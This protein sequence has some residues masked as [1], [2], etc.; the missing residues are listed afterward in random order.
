MS[1]VSTP[2]RSAGIPLSTVLPGMAVAILSMWATHCAP[3]ASS[4]HE[5]APEASTV[6]EFAPISPE[7]SAYAVEPPK[8][9]AS[10]HELT[11][12]SAHESTPE[13]SFDHESAPVP[14]EVA[15]PAAEPPKG[16]A[17]SYELSAH[18][19]TA[20]E[21]YHKLSACPVTAMEATYEFSAHHVKAKEVNH[22]LSAL[23]WMS[24]APLWVSLL[25]SA[26][27]APPW[28][29]ALPAL[30]ALPWLPALS[31]PPWLPALPA[32]PWLP[33]L[34]APPWLQA[35]QNLPWWTSAPVL[36]C[37]RPRSS[38]ASLSVTAPRSRPTSSARTWPSVPPPV[39][40]LSPH[41]PGLF[42]LSAR[43]RS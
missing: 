38:S 19:V 33:A 22:K 23:L 5:S 2:S 15:A 32:P 16:A 25:L 37:P 27:S 9:V 20:K 8:E 28:L 30:P 39:L 34:P 42:V 24:F 6:H 40:P 7:V 14:P 26:L 18:H 1:T 43:N 17:S 36:H 12:L 10:F 41:P 3:E 35:P 13:I 11:V 29:P 4:D 31:A 21:A